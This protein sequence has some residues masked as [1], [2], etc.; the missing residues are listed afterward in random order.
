MGWY[1]YYRLL[2]KY[3]GKLN[4]A[5]KEELHQ[6]KHVDESDSDSAKAYAT[7]K[8]KE[9]I[10]LKRIEKLRVQRLFSPDHED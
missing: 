3:E 5:T 9:D 7:S 6:A 10:R 8:W 4:K 1:Q 2:D